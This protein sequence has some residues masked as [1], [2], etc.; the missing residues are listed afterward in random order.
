MTVPLIDRR[1]AFKWV[2][3]ASSAL[4]T[5]GSSLR[6]AIAAASPGSA[7]EGYGRDPALLAT[8]HPGDLWPLTLT[9]AERLTTAALC[10]LIIPADAVSP[11][12]SAV[13]VVDFVDEW[14]SAPYPVHRDDRTLVQHGLAALEARAS[15]SFGRAF[16][17]LSPAEQR[18]LCDPICYVPKAPPALAEA[19]RFFARFR[20]LTAGGFYSSP[21]GTRDLGYVGNVALARFDGPP[22]EV[23]KRAGL[24]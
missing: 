15:E 18:R 5:L 12:A 10:D 1:T 6:S 24:A 3:A 13:G 7:A 17:V 23:L 19:A 16:P 14:V 9:P 20:D 11:A 4:P 22:L 8:H 2:L 21:E